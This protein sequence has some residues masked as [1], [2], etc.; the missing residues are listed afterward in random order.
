[1]GSGM[2]FVADKHLELFVHSYILEPIIK[3][4][5]SKSEPK[6]SDGVTNEDRMSSGLS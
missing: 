3:S 2:C 5:L 6:K 1:M 4:P